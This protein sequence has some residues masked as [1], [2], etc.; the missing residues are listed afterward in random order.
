M[1]NNYLM[2]LQSFS[3]YR[4]VWQIAFQTHQNV[5]A[6]GAYI[7]SCSSSGIQKWMQERIMIWRRRGKKK[8]EEDDQYFLIPPFKSSSSPSSIFSPP[9]ISSPL[10]TSSPR[11]PSPSP[12][13][14]S[15]SF[16]NHYTVLLSWSTSIY[17]KGWLNLIIRLTSSLPSKWSSA[18]LEGF[19]L[20]GEPVTGMRGT[21]DTERRDARCFPSNPKFTEQL[22]AVWSLWG[23][24]HK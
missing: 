12:S 24:Q 17:S 9:A 8:T 7:F 22:C 13:P 20:E 16:P 3:C 6:G 14:S 2:K 11:P 1:V 4:S 18:E 23:H 21:E 5:F 19:V 10:S 15:V